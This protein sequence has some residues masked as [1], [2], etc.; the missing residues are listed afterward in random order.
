MLYITE[1]RGPHVMLITEEGHPTEAVYLPAPGRA[2]REFQRYFR[3][4]KLRT[5]RRFPSLH[6]KPRPP[7]TRRVGRLSILRLLAYMESQ[8]FEVVVYVH[9]ITRRAPNR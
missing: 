9:P 3:R 4:W 2:E 6:W 7:N 8:G 1:E 5:E